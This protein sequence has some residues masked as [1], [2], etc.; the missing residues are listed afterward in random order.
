MNSNTTETCLYNCSDMINN[1]SLLLLLVHPFTVSFP[2]QPSRCQKGK[3]ILDL[4]E[5]RDDGVWGCGGI[6]W[7]ICKQSVPHSRQITTPSLNFYRL[8]ALP[9]AQCTVSSLCAD[10]AY[11][12]SVALPIYPYKPATCHAAVHHA[13]V[14]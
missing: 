4:N 7:T 5:A 13:T 8:D 12:N 9:Y 11:A 10:A 2:G 14:D 3:T 6:S 1:T